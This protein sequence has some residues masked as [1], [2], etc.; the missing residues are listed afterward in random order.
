MHLIKEGEEAEGPETEPLQGGGDRRAGIRNHRKR[1]SEKG[2]FLGESMVR[3]AVVAGGG[4]NDPSLFKS[5]LLIC[6]RNV[7]SPRPSSSSL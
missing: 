1:D 2:G 5:Y 3:V 4:K 7:Q 6:L